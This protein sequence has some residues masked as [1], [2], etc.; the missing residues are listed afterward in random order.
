MHYD[1]TRWSTSR[2]GGRDDE[3]YSGVWGQSGSDVIVV[4][5]SITS[6]AGFYDAEAF[7]LHYGRIQLDRAHLDPVVP[8]VGDLR[9]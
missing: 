9:H 7:I 1:G 6:Y 3:F 8:C 5:T 4:G 2:L